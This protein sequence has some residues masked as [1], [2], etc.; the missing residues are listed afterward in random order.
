MQG[1]RKRGKGGKRGAAAKLLC[2]VSTP[3]VRWRPPAAL[4]RHPRPSLSP[5]RNPIFLLN[6]TE[7]AN[8]MLLEAHSLRKIIPCLGKSVAESSATCEK[9]NLFCVENNWK[10][11]QMHLAR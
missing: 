9:T 4:I 6:K 10:R 1:C 3:P 11:N 7:L 5:F 8:Q 2:I